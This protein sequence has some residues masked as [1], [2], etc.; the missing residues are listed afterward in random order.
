MATTTSSLQQEVNF[1]EGDDDADSD[2]EVNNAI[3]PE[4]HGKDTSVNYGSPPECKTLLQEELDT[5][6]GEE[7]P[8]MEEQPDLAY[9]DTVVFT[10]D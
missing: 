9:Q 8:Q 3:T 10:T 2:E 4:P 1:L 6:P 7:E 5:I